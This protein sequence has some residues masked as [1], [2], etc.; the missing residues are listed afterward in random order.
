MLT[1]VQNALIL[2]PTSPGDDWVK[3]GARSA[4]RLPSFSSAWF[5]EQLEVVE[6]SP[7]LPNYPYHKH[8]FFSLNIL[9]PRLQ[10]NIETIARL[11]YSFQNPTRLISA[12][13]TNSERNTA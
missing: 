7:K 1:Q 9:P 2:C 10:F 5:D 13:W 8:N 6:E 3:E 12:E 11:A 4:C